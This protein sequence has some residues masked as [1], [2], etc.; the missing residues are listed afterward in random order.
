MSLNIQNNTSITHTPDI[1]SFSNSLRSSFCDDEEERLRIEDEEA[2]AAR[3]K[4]EEDTHLRIDFE[5]SAEATGTAIFFQHKE[6]ERLR[7][8][9]VTAEAARLQEQH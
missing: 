3:L 2:V 1:T 4:H 8:E 7:I 6:E 5:T 9:D